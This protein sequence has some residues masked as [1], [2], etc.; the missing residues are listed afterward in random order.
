VDI[1]DV[2]SQ[3][4]LSTLIESPVKLPPALVDVEG[5]NG[6]GVPTAVVVGEVEPV[7]VVELHL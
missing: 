7:S 3:S 6:N 4:V 5:Q 2:S 1:L